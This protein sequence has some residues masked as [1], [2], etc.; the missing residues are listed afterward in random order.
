M[1]PTGID[2]AKKASSIRL[3]PM[4]LPKSAAGKTKTNADASLYM[5]IAENKKLFGNATKPGE[6][7]GIKRTNRLRRRQQDLERRKRLDGERQG[8]GSSGSG[9]GG[10]SDEDCH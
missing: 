2:H 7:L 5:K 1:Y 4:E 6:I 8:L 9:A 10:S 3:P